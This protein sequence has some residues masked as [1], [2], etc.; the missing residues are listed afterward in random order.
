MALNHQ[1][2]TFL[3]R[4]QDRQVHNLLQGNLNQHKDTSHLHLDFN[5]SSNLKAFLHMA[6]MRLKEVT[7]LPLK[8]DPLKIMVEGI[9]ANNKVEIHINKVL[10]HKVHL[11]DNTASFQVVTT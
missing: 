7:L 2:C 1:Q 9:M 4:V 3:Q 8:G 10:H 5:I 11:Q 6:E